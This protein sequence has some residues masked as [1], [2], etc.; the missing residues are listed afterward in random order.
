[1][2][3]LRGAL[4][5]VIND[6]ARKNNLAKENDTGF[7]GEDTREG[8]TA[9]VSIQHPDPQFESQT[10]VKLMNAEVQ[11]AVQQV[12]G[13]ALTHF[14]EENPTAARAIIS[15]CQTSAK[16]RDAAR[17]ARDLVIRKSALESMTLP[18]KLA[19][20]SERNP[21][22]AELYIVE[23]NSAGGS[24]K[25]GRD[26]HFQ[27]ILPLRGKIL[28]TERA[29]LDRI[30]T[31]NEVK[32]LISAIGTG[33]RDQ[34]DLDGLRYGKIVLMTDADVDG[35]HIRTLLLTFFFRNML[36]I[37]EHGHLF[38]AQ[39]PLYRV[40]YRDQFRY[41]NSDVERDQIISDFGAPIEKVTIQRYKGLG[42]MNPDQLWETTMSPDHRTFLQVSIEDAT[43]AEHTFELLM[44]E[45]V[46]P[47]TRFIQAHARDVSNLDI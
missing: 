35:S 32:A 40:A 10:K 30:L 15:K 8:L 45:E 22:R 28:N 5:R 16:A 38:I 47:R 26:R 21:D 11:T 20:C 25:Q 39:P 3:G 14:L 6:Y 46:P 12:V 43:K 9:V 19:D 1:M 23:G 36:P 31:N 41:A 33:V 18:G 34:F 4:T 17:R 2:T 44:G 7:S 13:D 24:A 29:S 27:A 37:I 42:E